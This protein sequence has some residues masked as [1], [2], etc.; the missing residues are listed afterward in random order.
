[1]TTSIIKTKK[2]NLSPEAQQQEQEE[3]NK[4]K[5][6]HQLKEIRKQYHTVFNATK[7][8][9]VQSDKGTENISLGNEIHHKWSKSTTL[10]VG[11]STVSGI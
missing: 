2:S 9:L 8:Q 11:D 6:D 1:M 4:A 7:K 5:L 10:I 3:V